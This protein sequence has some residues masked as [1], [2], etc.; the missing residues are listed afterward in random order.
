MLKARALLVEADAMASKAGFG[1]IKVMFECW[2]YN[3][4]HINI[5]EDGAITKAEK[6]LDAAG[7]QHL[8][9]ES[10]MRSLM[11]AEARDSWDKSIT[12]GEF[13]ALTKENIGATFARLHDARQSMFEDGVIS[14]FRRLSWC[15]KTNQPFKFGKRI[16][17]DYLFSH[18]Y[19][20]HRQTD[21]LDDLMRVMSIL[22]GKPEPDH[23]NGTY[24]L[25]SG[26]KQQG[27]TAENDY[28]HI[29]WYL[30]GSGHITFKRLDLV[31]QLNEILAKRFP[32][33]LSRDKK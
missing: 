32:R 1:S 10:G 30:K 9:H 21:E 17:V 11:N 16:I 6:E 28:L 29:R 33:V 24:Q 15:Y 3:R 23:R 22:D 20:N 14:V 12:N 26:S 31:D 4:S 25:I 13:P 7:W 19:P 27:N 5:L 18:G 8:M 2:R